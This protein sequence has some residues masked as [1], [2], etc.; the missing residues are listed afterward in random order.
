M[1]SKKDGQGNCE[2]IKYDISLVDKNTEFNDQQK[3]CFLGD[4][5][6]ELD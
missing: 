5:S 2:L 1:S 3:V 6:F 4:F